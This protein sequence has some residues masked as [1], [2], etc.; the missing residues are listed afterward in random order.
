M[1]A[2]REHGP[3]AP[4]LG[5]RLLVPGDG[6]LVDDRAQ[7]R[8]ARQRVADDELLG[9]LHEQP[10]ELVVDRALDVDPAVGGALL[11][12]VAERGPHDPL[13]RLL[14]VRALEHDGRVLAAHLHDARARVA[15]CEKLR[16]SSKPTS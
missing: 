7:E 16:N 15:P 13:G 1:L 5:D 11:P 9:L 2:A 3:V 10:D 12:A 14:E 8:G 4:R 6:P